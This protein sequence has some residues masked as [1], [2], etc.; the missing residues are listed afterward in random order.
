MST[1]ESSLAASA[2]PL[3][4]SFTILLE[5]FDVVGKISAFL[6]KRC[7]QPTLANLSSMVPAVG[8]VSLELRLLQI[9]AIAPEIVALR[10]APKRSAEEGPL[11]L[12]LAYLQRSTAKR[13][14]AGLRKAMILR[15]NVEHEKVKAA[16]PERPTKKRKQR[17]TAKATAARA[18]AS[19]PKAPKAWSASFDLTSDSLS[20]AALLGNSLRPP[21]RPTVAAAAARSGADDA[22]KLC[23]VGSADGTAAK[24]GPAQI[25]A[26]LRNAPFYDAQVVHVHEVAPRRARTA[27]LDVALCPAL[28]RRVARLTGGQPLWLHQARAINAARAGRDV[29]VCTATASG[30]SI[31]Y[32]I[33]ILDAIVRGSRNGAPANGAGA[34][35]GTAAALVLFPT[36]AL[37]QDQLRAV[38]E[39]IRGVLPDAEASGG[40]TYV[41]TATTSASAA[42][43]VNGN[44]STLVEC[45]A[46]DGDTSYADRDD[47]RSS[48][49]I[50]LSNPDFVHH[51]LGQHRR[52]ERF[53]ACL[54]YVVIDEAHTYRGVFGSHVAAVISRLVRICALYGAAPTFVCSSATIANPTKF[55]QSLIGAPASRPG[56]KG[57]VVVSEDGSPSGLKQL[58][59]WNPPLKKKMESATTSAQR[60]EGGDPTPA[61]AATQGGARPAARAPVAAA[62]GGGASSRASVTAAQPTTAASVSDSPTATAAAEGCAIA[63]RGTARCVDLSSSVALRPGDAGERRSAIFETALLLASFTRSGV[64]TLCFAKSR[65]LVELIL[66]HT[67]RLLRSVAPEAVAKV[68]AYRGGYTKSDRREIERSLFSGQLLGVVATSALEVGVD[69]GCL[70]ATLH[71]GFPG[72]MSSLWQQVGRAGRSATRGS[73]AVLIL[74]DSPLD[75]YVAARPAEILARSAEAVTFDRANDFVLRAHLLVAAAELPL[76]RD[77]A[78]APLGIS[79]PQRL[80][81]LAAPLIARRELLVTREGTHLRAHS[82][83]AKGCAGK[84]SLRQIDPITF[85][86]TVGGTQPLRVIDYV[87]Y[88]RAFFE[89]HTNA[90]YLHQGKTYIVTELDLERKRATA[91]LSPGLTYRTQPRD[92]TDCL[93]VARQRRRGATDAGTGVCYGRVRVRTS[94]WGYRKVDNRS[95]RIIGMGEF[96]L[97]PLELDTN[98]CWI[99]I[100]SAVRSAVELAGHEF[101]AA[102]HA[103]EHALTAVLP[104]FI[105]CDRADIGTEHIGPCVPLSS[106]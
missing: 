11:V 57:V 9:A 71:L 19:A 91:V 64:R 73:L 25:V 72:S 26:A 2:L 82:L 95:G 94:V 42:D 99:E 105:A 39:L 103:A 67:Q 13:R 20:V 3:P 69:I 85:T 15:L 38:N 50:V 16:G 104:L 22:T 43:G 7:V 23:F 96:S 80:A 83:A 35:G 18:K 8:G 89:L 87:P 60:K 63:G 46:L 12:E 101:L 27:A 45:A 88:S 4:A 97:P 100:A 93:V 54:E 21:P 14:R 84:V 77:C 78:D 86:V 17:A 75:Q 90:V 55:V 47:A 49:N 40:R 53:F 106:C 56:G 62:A 68:M 98:A 37:A 65:K 58:V 74:F 1:V 33:P 31:C 34:A 102:V 51:L 44:L 48:A 28:A 6:G 10:W 30:K 76:R 81:H 70:D 5:T 79:L 59:V 92:H 36:K 29:A 61:L 41:P 66:R 32:L 52:W 24:P